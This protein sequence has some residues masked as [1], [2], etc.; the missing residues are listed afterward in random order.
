MS[1]TEQ[2]KSS[3]VPK[4]RSIKVGITPSVVEE[5]FESGSNP[6]LLKLNQKIHCGKK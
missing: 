2:N 5:A 3:S 6:I 4:K 1:I